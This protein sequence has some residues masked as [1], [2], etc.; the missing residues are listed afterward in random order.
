MARSVIYRPFEARAYETCRLLE[1]SGG[2]T[3]SNA[4]VKK[5]AGGVR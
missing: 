5:A 3:G 2:E 4:A 1:K